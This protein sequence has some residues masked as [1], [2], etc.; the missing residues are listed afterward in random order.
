MSEELKDQRI[1]IMMSPSEVK[2]IDDWMFANRIKSRAEAIRRLCQISIGAES[3]VNE[4]HKSISEGLD[5]TKAFVEAA[6]PAK[7]KGDR[8]AVKEAAVKYGADL[9]RTLKKL[10]AP[11][12]DLRSLYHF[13]GKEGAETGDFILTAKDFLDIMNTIERPH[14][15]STSKKD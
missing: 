15:P 4:M 9:L 14:K 8:D 10:H 3:S 1:P 11:L 12:Q 5:S 6:T 13:Y 7:D 2:A